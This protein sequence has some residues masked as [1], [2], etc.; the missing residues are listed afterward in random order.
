[1]PL[2]LDVT[3]TP[4]AQL[5]GWG[6]LERGVI[7][8]RAGQNC[9]DDTTAGPSERVARVRFADEMALK[10][11]EVIVELRGVIDRDA[12]VQLGERERRARLAEFAEDLDPDLVAE[13][14]ERV[15]GCQP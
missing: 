6:P 2:D 11:V 1:V 8:D 14:A 15:I 9:L 7:G 3:V 10:S 4:G 12:V 13:R 5:V